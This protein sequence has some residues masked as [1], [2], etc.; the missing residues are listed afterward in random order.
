[1]DFKILMETE[2]YHVISE[3]IN[4]ITHNDKIL[5]DAF[6]IAEMFCHFHK[7]AA[8]NKTKDIKSDVS[9]ETFLSEK[10]KRTNTF[11]L[12]PVELSNV[13]RAIKELKPKSSFGPDGI[14]TKFI[15]NSI[16]FLVQQLKFIINKLVFEGTFPSLSSVQGSPQYINEINIYHRITNQFSKY[17]DSVKLLKSVSINNLVC[18]VKTSLTIKVNMLIHGPQYCKYVCICLIQK[19]VTNFYKGFKQQ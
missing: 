17:Q 19:F 12:N 14:P 2:K 5:D 11:H 3:S 15:C 4:S 16:G 10:D 8:F 13:W 6:R 1:M 7:Y 18:T 9:F